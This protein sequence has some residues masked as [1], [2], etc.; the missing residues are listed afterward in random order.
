M[1]MV[2]IVLLFLSLAS[3]EI[4]NIFDKFQENTPEEF[5]VLKFNKYINYIV[6]LYFEEGKLLHLILPTRNVQ[7]KEIANVYD[8]QEIISKLSTKYQILL[9]N[10]DDFELKDSFIFMKTSYYVIF[11]QE[12]MIEIQ[13]KSRWKMLRRYYETWNSK[14]CFIFVILQ[15]GSND[16]NGTIIDIINSLWKINVFKVVIILS[17]KNEIKLITAS[18]FSSENRCRKLHNDGNLNAY[19]TNYNSTLKLDLFAFSSPLN[20]HGCS[21]IAE[22]FTF[23]PYTYEIKNFTKYDL[24]TGIELNIIK[25]LADKHNINIV[26]ET[27]DMNFYPWWHVKPDGS[28]QGIFWDLLLYEIDFAFAGNMAYYLE[29]LIVDHTQWHSFGSYSWYVPKPNPLR[30]WKDVFIVFTPSLWATII[31]TF[32]LS[33]ITYYIMNKISLTKEK[34]A[35]EKTYWSCFI[36]LYSLCIGVPISA[37][38]NST[39]LRLLFFT[40]AFYSLT[41]TTVYQKTLYSLLIHPLTETQINSLDEL[42]RSG[43]KICAEHTAYTMNSLLYNNT[44]EMNQ[45]MVCNNKTEMIH[46]FI[47][48]K[49]TSILDKTEFIESMQSKYGYYF[50]KIPEIYVTYFVTMVTSKGHIAFDCLNAVVQRSVEGGLVS[51]WRSDAQMKP[52]IDSTYGTHYPLDMEDFHCA[53]LILVSGLSVSVIFFL[54]EVLLKVHY[55]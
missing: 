5:E 32:L 42:K 3:S 36:I 26:F 22:T 23:P 25:I 21:M 9:S 2:L 14:A 39:Y 24:V 11:I 28:G 34:T 17:D 7:I 27:P 48:H 1:I 43:L 30:P 29:Y 4:I 6:P 8:F 10:H 38:P 37:T 53:F 50:P 15:S 16:N 12:N 45:Y 52:M 35:P 19:H 33:S 44:N 51:K 20:F 47:N 54:I 55:G 18:P 13:I 31:F 40:W 41:L 49:N 46:N